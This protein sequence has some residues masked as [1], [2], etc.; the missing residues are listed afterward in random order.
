MRKSTKDLYRS[1]ANDNCQSLRFHYNCGI[2]EH[3]VGCFNSPE[4]WGERKL[5]S[6]IE[7]VLTDIHPGA[8]LFFSDNDNTSNIAKVLTNI[9]QYIPLGINNNSY[10]RIYSWIVSKESIA[11]YKRKKTNAKKSAKSK[12]RKQKSEQA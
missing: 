3:R 8:A 5:I 12:T 1:I 6:Y 10:N 4:T 9:G 11:N 2:R 7:Y